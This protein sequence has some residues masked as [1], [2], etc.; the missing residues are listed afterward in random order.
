M[1]RRQLNIS[2]KKISETDN[3]K[4]TLNE[5][6][7]LKINSNDEYYIISSTT[8]LQKTIDAVSNKTKRINFK[9]EKFRRSSTS[10]L[11]C[12]KEMSKS[13]LKYDYDNQIKRIMNETFKELETL[14]NDAS[15]SK[16]KSSVQIILSTPSKEL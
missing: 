8:K 15:N 14:I 1:L 10:H 9:I 6:E 4:D 13:D 11:K 12:I 3:K 7:T 2:L 16:K 5:T